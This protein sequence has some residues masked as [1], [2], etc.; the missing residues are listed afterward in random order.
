MGAFGFFSFFGFFESGKMALGTQIWHFHRLKIGKKSE[1]SQ[2]CQV[3]KK[4]FSAKKKKKIFFLFFFSNMNFVFEGSFFFLLTGL[5]EKNT[6][7]KK[8]TFTFFFLFFLQKFE[9][10]HFFKG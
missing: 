8:C 7:E 10:F 1:K 9:K 3:E 4:K 5:L 6:F 2:K